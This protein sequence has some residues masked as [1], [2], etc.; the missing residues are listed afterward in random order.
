VQVELDG[1]EVLSRPATDARHPATV[2]ADGTAS[3]RNI[4]GLQLKAKLE[5]PKCHFTGRPFLSGSRPCPCSSQACWRSRPWPANVARSGGVPEAN[6]SLNGL[7]AHVIRSA[8][9][10]SSITRLPTSVILMRPPTERLSALTVPRCAVVASPARTRP[11]SARRV[12]P[13]VCM[14]PRSC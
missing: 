9:D 11:A 7:L 1:S 13:R 5:N 14:I 2:P 12:R 8:L 10:Q 3:H 4:S 6:G